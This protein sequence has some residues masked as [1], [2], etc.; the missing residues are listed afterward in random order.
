MKQIIVAAALVGIG[1]TAALAVADPKRDAILADLAT[2]TKAADPAFT[3]FDAER[4]KTFWFAAH[5]GG[6]P[7][8]PSC[9][10]CHTKDPK[11]VGQTRAGKEIAPM[12]VS[13]TPNRFTDPEKVAKW[14][15]RNCKTV[16]GRECTPV[17]KGDII[18]FLASQ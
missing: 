18:T 17:E 16:L 9:T 5:A 2:Q 4:G 3:A 7:E 13:K 15:L 1:A 14:L 6:K 12:A 8:T 11:A 10:T